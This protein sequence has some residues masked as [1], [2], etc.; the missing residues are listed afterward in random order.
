MGRRT[1]SHFLGMP[2]FSRS[3]VISASALVAWFALWMA[4]R[5]PQTGT[6]VSLSA[7]VAKPG[8]MPVSAAG[9]DRSDHSGRLFTVVE[10]RSASELTAALPA[11]SRLV[12]YVRIDRAWLAGK[13]S[14]FW[15]SPGA[16]RLEIPLPDGSSLV[17]II[18]GD[19]KSTRLNSSH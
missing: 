16:G 1:T 11:P 15:Q 18:D 9:G 6:A 13:H 19:R 5:G 2:S 17:V 4:G 14:P 12:H 7:G 10:P 3:L 8:H